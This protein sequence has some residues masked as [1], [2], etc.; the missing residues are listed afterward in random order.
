VTLRGFITVAVLLAGSPVLTVAG[1]PKEATPG[2]QA[3]R[4]F[5]DEFVADWIAG[6]V[7][8]A[9]DK[10]FVISGKNDRQRMETNFRWLEER[11]GSPLAA[12]FENNGIPKEYETTKENEPVHEFTFKYRANTTRAPKLGMEVGVSLHGNGRYSIGFNSCR[13]PSAETKQ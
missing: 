9:I 5:S 6:K 12:V 10:W 4:K 8:E 11:C 13:D 7:P 2:Q 3:A 1:G